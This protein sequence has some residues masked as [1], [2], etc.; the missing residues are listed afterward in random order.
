[1]QRFASTKLTILARRAAPALVVDYAKACGTVIQPVDAVA[2]AQRAVTDRELERL[3]LAI[4]EAQL[5][6]VLGVATGIGELDLEQGRQVVH[7][8]TPV[9]RPEESG[10]D[11]ACLFSLVED[12]VAELA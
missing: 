12:G 10:T 4:A 11:H 9:G 8:L 2:E 3:S 6:L 5:E 7:H 1:L